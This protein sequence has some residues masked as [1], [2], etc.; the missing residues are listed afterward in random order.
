MTASPEEQGK[1]SSPRQI[2]LRT[3]LSVSLAVLVVMAVAPVIAVSYFS[4]SDTAGRLITE[5]AELI[6]DGLETEIRGLLDPIVSQLGYARQAVM[7]GRVDPNDPE[8]LRKFVRGLLGGTPQ[9]TGIGHLRPDRSMR[10]WERDGFVESIEPPE[11]L[12]LAGE[13]IEAARKGRIAYWSAP[14]YSVVMGDAILSYRV[15]LEQESAFR[16]VLVA[17]VASEGLSRYVADVSRSFGVTAFVLV[18]RDRILTYPAHRASEE[19]SASTALPL[20]STA[21]DPV[22]AGIWH[23]PQTLT[24]TAEPTRSRGHWNWVGDVSY[25]FFY[26]ELTDYGPE[27]L[28]VAVAIPAVDSRWDR[29]AATIAAGV[30]LVLMLIAA[31]VAWRLGRMLSRPAGDFDRALGSIAALEFDEVALPV[32]ARSRVREWRT[33]ARRLESTARALAAFQT[34]L[35]RALVRRLFDRAKEGVESRELEITVMFIDL[36]GFTAFSRG[37]SAGDLAAY[38]NGIFERVGPIIEASGGVIDKYTGDGL[39]AFWGAP[40]LQPDHAR[41]A[42]RAAAEIARAFE[43]RED[44]AAEGEPRMRIGLHCG[45]AVVGNIGFAG[46]INYTLVGDTVNVAQRTESALRGLQPERAVVI[47]ATQ[48]VLNALGDDDLPLVKA[49]ELENSPRTAYLC[50]RTRDDS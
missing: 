14:F 37:R 16:G 15:A 46:R 49:D 28:I 3:L 19:E 42:C 44:I 41:R 10:R 34:Y 40:D 7:Q 25:G 5:R 13:A 38:L 45:A 27:P 1:A 36:E 32:L 47:G 2:S 11:R 24:Q 21:R 29:W 9:V 39:L 26:R 4:A 33:V 20:L 48:E 17:G 35:P 30:G 6:V 31:A 23:D 50:S 43:E 18:G 22:V 12:P 8:D